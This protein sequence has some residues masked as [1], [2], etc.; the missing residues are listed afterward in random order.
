[1]SYTDTELKVITININTVNAWC[2][3]NL[4]SADKIQQEVVTVHLD[5]EKLEKHFVEYLLRI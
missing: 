5:Y 1:M 4:P 2:T 3:W